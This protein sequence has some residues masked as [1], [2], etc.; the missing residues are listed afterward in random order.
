MT[1]N[2]PDWTAHVPLKTVGVL[3]ATHIFGKNIETR[4]T[5]L[6]GKRRFHNAV[7]SVVGYILNPILPS[8]AA[9]AAGE[10]HDAEASLRNIRDCFG[11]IFHIQV[12]YFKLLQKLMPDRFRSKKTGAEF[13][14]NQFS[15]KGP[16]LI[17]SERRYLILSKIDGAQPYDLDLDWN[18]EFDWLEDAIRDLFRDRLFMAQDAYADTLRLGEWYSARDKNLILPLKTIMDDLSEYFDHLGLAAYLMARNGR[19]RDEA[20]TPLIRENLLE[21]CRHLERFCIDMMSMNVFSIVKHDLERLGSER[22]EKIIRVRAGDSAY[23]GHYGF[24]RR[25]EEYTD[26]LVDLYEA[27]EFS[28]NGKENVSDTRRLAEK[29]S[30]TRRL[31][32]SA[33]DTRRV[34]EKGSDTRRVAENASDTRRVADKGGDT[35]RM[36]EDGSDTRR[37]AEKGSDTRRMGE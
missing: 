35:R 33:N 2:L 17:N 4:H 28:P 24:Q 19:R 20:N 13:H 11:Y 16:T 3:C 31:A 1:A 22:V 9:D 30:D 14:L 10:D 25:R 5:V 27:V 37:L 34:A 32:E 15:A 6:A 36:V 18:A 8:F 21:T 7:E 23:A 12:E 29:G 26:L